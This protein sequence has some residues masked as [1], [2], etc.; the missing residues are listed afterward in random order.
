MSTPPAAGPRGIAALHPAS[1]AMVMATGI[2]SIAVWLEGFETLGAVLFAI[3]IIAAIVL[4]VLGILRCVWYPAAMRADI[5]DHGRVVGFFTIIAAAA[6]LGSQAL[7]IADAWTAAAVLWCVAI[8]LWAVLTYA[9]FTVLTVKEIKP[10]LA[11]GINGGWL[12]AVVAPQSVAV[13]GAQLAPGLTVYREAALFFSLAMWLGAGMLY[14]WIIALIFYRYTFFPLHPA[15]LSPPYWIN[16]G[17]VAIS[18][19]A[20][21]ILLADAPVSPLLTRLA[22]FVAGFTLLF[23]ATATWWIPM[24]LTLGVW[25]HV[26]RGVGMGYDPL[27]WGAVFPLGMYTVCTFRLAHAIEMPM[28]LVIPRVSVYVALAA[29]LAMA[30]ALIRHLLRHRGW[31][32]G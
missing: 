28:L 2:V 13:L 17:A 16:M 12:L 5:L 25:R 8:V 14:I 23:W 32:A 9:V 22:P 3:N 11:E 15:D 1:F 29:W 30:G 19:L 31:A 26:Y 18:T 27:Y 4:V 10:T 6:V 20:G 24:L 21:S 7:V